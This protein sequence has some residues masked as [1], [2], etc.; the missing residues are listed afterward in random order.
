MLQTK[1]ERA[2][3]GTSETKSTGFRGKLNQVVAAVDSFMTLKSLGLNATSALIQLVQ[4]LSMSGVKGV[5]IGNVYKNAAESTVGL[6]AFDDIYDAS[7]AIRARVGAGET[8]LH[9]R[10]DSGLGLAGSLLRGRENVGNLLM[11]GITFTDARMSAGIWADQYQKAMKKAGKEWKM[12]DKIDMNSPESI[13]AIANADGWVRRSMGTGEK[14]YRAALFDD[15]LGRAVF[16]LGKSA[17]TN[18]STVLREM[19]NAGL[20]RKTAIALG[21]VGMT[22]AITSIRTVMELAREEA[23]MNSKFTSDKLAKMKEAFE[24]G[25]MERIK[26]ALKA[27]SGEVAIPAIVPDVEFGGREMGPA[28]MLGDFYKGGK[29][30]SDIIGGGIGS[31]AQRATE[32]IAAVLQATLFPGEVNKLANKITVPAKERADLG[33]SMKDK[34]AD[35]SGLTTEV[36]DAEIKRKKEDALESKQKKSSFAKFL[37]SRVDDGNWYSDPKD[38]FKELRAYAQ[39]EANRRGETVTSEE[40]KQL[41]NKFVA[42]LKS[43]GE[44]DAVVASLK[45]ESA[46]DYLAQKYGNGVFTQEAASRAN[47]LYK[48]G[49]LTKE[50]KKAMVEYVKNK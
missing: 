37:Q 50:D 46:V 41:K 2:A 42:Y 32:G 30:A 15:P 35:V 14:A 19:T 39:E 21:F 25:Y 48:L 20:P 33:K 3:S 26:W 23:G 18:L 10:I 9:S 40:F 43:Y 38:K 22:A 28:A 1:L 17:T 29:K 45:P 16:F 36:A 8:V 34:G 47:E 11:K 6:D 27:M 7:P 31:P 24:K 44:P 13:E 4:P 5:N 49:L 12:G